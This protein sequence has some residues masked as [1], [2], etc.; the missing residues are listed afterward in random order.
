MGNVRW[1]MGDKAIK[2]LINFYE[3]NAVTIYSHLHQTTETNNI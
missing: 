3:T 2:E 1:E